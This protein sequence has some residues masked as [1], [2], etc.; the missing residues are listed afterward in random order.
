MTVDDRAVTATP[1]D[2]TTGSPPTRPDGRGAV[3]RGF[4]RIRARLHDGVVQRSTA[5]LW[6]NLLIAAAVLVAFFTVWGG[7]TRELEPADVSVAALK[8]FAIWCL[9]FIPGW[10]YVRFLGQRA[11]A[12]WSEYVLNLHRLAL[13]EPQFLPMPPVT[14]TYYAEWKAG[15]PD[16]AVPADNVYRQKFDAYY[17][18]S[19]AD[20]ASDPNFRVRSETMFPVFVATAI[21][22]AGWTAV[23]WDLRF[24]SAAST[25]W[26]VLKF[27]F[28][29]AYVFTLQSLIRRFFQSDLRPS[30]YANAIVR[31][32]VVSGAVLSLHQ[33]VDWPIRREAAIAFVVGIFPVMAFQALNRLASSVLRVAVPQATPDYP[34]S[35]LDGLNV[36]YEARLV[37]EGIEDMQNLVS[38]NLVDVILHTRVPVG[39][40]VDWIDQAHLYL[41]LDRV[42][43]GYWERRRAQRHIESQIKRTPAPGPAGEQGD[44]SADV[45]ARVRGS[46]SRFSRAGTYTRTALRQLGIRTATD[47][48]RAFPAADLDPVHQPRGR[49][50][51]GYRTVLPEGADEDQLR[52]LVRVLDED[53]DLAP[54]WNWKSRGVQVRDLTRRP[55]SSRLREVMSS[56]N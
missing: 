8:L 43:R 41:H 6:M 35:Q 44:E 47:L 36:W 9:A 24:A 42:E 37:E 7:P 13:D 25:V 19:V 50:A 27:S 33:V 2:R 16:A 55:R 32:V 49:L 5:A 29:G 26:D 48:L 51:V 31:V 23:L 14:S 38:A 56:A 30:G 18:R 45:H 3:R 52:T 15:G 20:N 46:V 17:G 1:D 54:V 22:A 21:F 28:V 4:G 12:L 34:L 53:T 39:R 11:G 40:L 10:L